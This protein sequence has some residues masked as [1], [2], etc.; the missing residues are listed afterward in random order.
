MVRATA[1]SLIRE[2]EA[3]DTWSGQ[4]QGDSAGPFSG[5]PFDQGNMPGFGRVAGDN[6][7]QATSFQPLI[8]G[9]DWSKSFLFVLVRLL[10][11]R[12]E[13]RL[14]GAGICESQNA[15]NPIRPSLVGGIDSIVRVFEANPGSASNWPR[16]AGPLFA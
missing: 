10:G 16:S 2:S 9:L 8:C 5:G 15:A 6:P 11:M 14:A 3:R 1:L 13:E 4:D 12:I 7:R